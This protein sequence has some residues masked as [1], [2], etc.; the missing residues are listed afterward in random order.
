MPRALVALG[1]NLGDRVQTVQ[2]AVE[3]IAQDVAQ[4]PLSVSRMHETT[5]V[6]GPA[7]Q[8]AFLN[9]AVACETSLDPDALH[10]ALKRIERELGRV[11]GERWG[12]RAIDLDLLLY[13]GASSEGGCAEPK[14]VLT[15]ELQVPHPRMSFR[16]FVLEPAVE[17]APQM[18]HPLIGWSV[19]QLLD[20]LNHAPQHVAVVGLA[21]SRPEELARAAAAQVG[22]CFVAE[23]LASELL[24]GPTDPSGPA[25]SRP[26][27]FRDRI[28][29]V[30][31]AANCPP[32]TTLISAFC[33][34][35][36]EE[37]ERPLERSRQPATPT[38][39]PIKLLVVLDDWA[40]LVAAKAG[41]SAFAG[42][43]HALLRWAV[44]DY[45]GP[46]LCAGRSDFEFQLNEITAAVVAM[47]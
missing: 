38:V 42:D 28:A 36:S 43:S 31:A 20:H 34:E 7:E 15:A 46:V 37:T 24:A 12:A 23:S 29:S 14:M 5:P 6:G 30:L 21:E 41:T 44:D 27:Q 19:E 10:E 18:I 47:R 25:L 17:V 26:I 35:E 45:Q 1:A 2:R 22:A 8:N 13:D 11:R 9:A 39:L 3:R 32:A 33:V 16:R 4:G 40:S